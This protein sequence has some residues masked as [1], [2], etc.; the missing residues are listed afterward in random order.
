MRNTWLL[1]ALVG[2]GTHPHNTISYPDM[3]NAQGTDDAATDVC[4]QKAKLVY[5]VDANGTFS[6]FDPAA[7]KFTDIGVMKCPATAEK[8][9]RKDAMASDAR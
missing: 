7:L 3:A 2:C 6:S 8:W 5:V 4:S 9:S 1:V